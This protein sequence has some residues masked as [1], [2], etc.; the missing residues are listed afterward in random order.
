MRDEVIVGSAERKIDIKFSISSYDKSFP[1]RVLYCTDK[2]IHADNI[3]NRWI[4][5]FDAKVL[6]LH[7]PKNSKSLLELTKNFF[8]F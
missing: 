6:L 1:F 5:N 4:L 3:K 7:F 2:K 8:G